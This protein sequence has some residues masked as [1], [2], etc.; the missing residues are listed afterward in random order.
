MAVL[1]VG[2]SVSPPLLP[3]WA[4]KNFDLSVSH[5]I[6]GVQFGL[7]SSGSDSLCVDVDLVCRWEKVDS[8][9]VYSIIFPESKGLFKNVLS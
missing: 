5:C 6:E 7:Y 3:F 9:S 1:T 4:F 8:V 2:F